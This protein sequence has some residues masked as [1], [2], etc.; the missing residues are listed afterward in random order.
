MKAEHR[1]ELETNVLAQQISRAYEGLKQGPSRSTVLWVGGAVAVV[2]IFLLFRWF[3]NSSESTSS[4]RWMKLDEVVFPEQLDLLLNENDLK[5][6]LQGRLARFKEARLNLG[7][8]LRDLASDPDRNV[9]RIEKATGLYEELSRSSGRVPLLHQEAL[10][11]AAKGNEALGEYEKARALYKQ[12]A[13]DYPASA[14]GKDAKKQ[15]ERLDDK[16]TQAELA[17]LKKAF[18]ATRSGKSE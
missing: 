2:L 5:D 6:A 18:S 17:E 13:D 7:Q 11:G 16:T 1:K 14:M 15:L 10:W 8:G 12:L 4:E 9:K 3:T